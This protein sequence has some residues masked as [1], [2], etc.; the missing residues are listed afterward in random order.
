MYF[1]WCTSVMLWPGPGVRSHGHLLASFVRV[2]SPGL[3]LA[4]SANLLISLILGLILVQP[5]LVGSDQVWQPSQP[6]WPRDRPPA[7]DIALHVHGRTSDRT[8]AST[9]DTVSRHSDHELPMQI[10]QSSWLSSA[11]CNSSS[12]TTCVGHV[13][14]GTGDPHAQH[15]KIAEDPFWLRQPRSSHFPSSLTSQCLSSSLHESNDAAESAEIICSCAVTSRIYWTLNHPNPVFSSSCWSSSDCLPPVL[16]KDAIDDLESE[17]KEDCGDRVVAILTR[18]KMNNDE[19]ENSTKVL[20]SG[21]WCDNDIHC[22]ECKVRK[23]QSLK[24]DCI[25]AF[26]KSITVTNMF[27]SSEFN[28]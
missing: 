18:I 5:R 16:S 14:H 20:S 24:N 23:L 11:G 1:R 28:E 8:R 12:V 7:R 19:M 17:V 13:S 2:A 6:P 21:H 27:K 15:G 9:R 26:T 10:F 22:Q 4:S 25:I 3:P